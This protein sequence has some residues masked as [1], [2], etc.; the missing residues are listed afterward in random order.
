MRS[1]VTGLGGSALGTILEIQLL[2]VMGITSFGGNPRQIQ[3]QQLASFEWGVLAALPGTL[4]GCS[5]SGTY[6][7]M[8][9][10][11]LKLV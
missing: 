7:R 1:N 10:L 6:P 2:S 11:F 4:P 9:G 5:P 3:F 8:A